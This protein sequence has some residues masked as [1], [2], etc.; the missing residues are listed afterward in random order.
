MSQFT[1]GYSM[2]TVADDRRR[3]TA[4]YAEK[5]EQGGIYLE[6]EKED[7][8]LVDTTL[9]DHITFRALHPEVA[10]GFY[11]GTST[12]RNLRWHRRS[13]FLDRYASLAKENAQ[14]AKR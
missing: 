9:P 14:W 2:F 5:G 4:L 12:H 11:V 7:H 6:D 3:I 10:P 8:L 1:Q 13:V